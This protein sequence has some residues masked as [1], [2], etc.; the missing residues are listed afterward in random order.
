MEIVAFILSIV[1]FVPFNMFR[2]LERMDFLR[3]LWLIP[4]I[5]C[6]ILQLPRSN[7]PFSSGTGTGT[8]SAGVEGRW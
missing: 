7:P 3:I 4:I 5:V 8:V 2:V 6:Y 1:L